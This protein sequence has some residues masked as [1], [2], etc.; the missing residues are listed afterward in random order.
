LMQQVRKWHLLGA[1]VKFSVMK[2]SWHFCEIHSSSSDWKVISGSRK[3]YHFS[4][5]F[6]SP[7]RSDT[8]VLAQA[9]LPAVP[10]GSNQT[11]IPILSH[12]S[13]RLSSLQPAYAHIQMYHHP[14]C[15]NLNNRVCM[16]L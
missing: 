5:S 4:V 9:V 11:C 13:E 15:F 1:T 16:F 2:E 14:A 3:G 8:V 10:V 12:G 7:D 6:T